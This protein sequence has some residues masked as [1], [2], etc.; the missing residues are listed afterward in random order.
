MRSTMASSVAMALKARASSPT[1][2]AEVSVTRW[3][4]SPSAMRRAAM[5]ISRSGDVIPRARTW[6]RARAIVAAMIG[7]TQIGTPRRNPTNDT[8]ELTP[9]ATTMATPSLSLIEPSRS[10][11]RRHHGDA[12]SP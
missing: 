10:S 4:Q 6:T 8:T 5:A 9:T 3:L 11:G 2:S 12:P 7:R 1:S